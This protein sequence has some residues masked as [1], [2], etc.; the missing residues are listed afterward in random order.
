MLQELDSHR[1]RVKTTILALVVVGLVVTLGLWLLPP[2]L[3]QVYGDSSN[4]ESSGQPVD[5][6]RV[7]DDCIWRP[8][9]ATLYRLRQV[10]ELRPVYMEDMSICGENPSEYRLIQSAE[11]AQRK[12]R[13]ISKN[14]RYLMEQDKWSWLHPTKKDLVLLA[15]S[16]KEFTQD[17]VE[18]VLLESGYTE[19]NI[20]N[21]T[22]LKREKTMR[23]EIFLGRQSGILYTSI[24]LRRP[25]EY[26]VKDHHSKD[27]DKNDVIWVTFHGRIISREPQENGKRYWSRE[28]WIDCRKEQYQYLSDYWDD[29]GKGRCTPDH[30]RWRKIRPK[31]GSK[32][33]Q[34]PDKIALRLIK[35]LSAGTADR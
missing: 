14:T 6:E 24:L 26:W 19:F 15:E 11:D 12:K 7:F 20:R 30:R 18:K 34:D 1:M 32:S 17:D 10:K 21:P 2:I 9:A 31:N 8:D 5:S 4:S 22:N 33:S 35:R 3:D 16:F 25:D 27:H 23:R 28:F 29:K 13:L